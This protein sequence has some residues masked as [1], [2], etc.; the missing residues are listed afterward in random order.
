MTGDLVAA[1]TNHRHWLNEMARLIDEGKVKVHISKVFPLEQVAEAHKESE[2]FHTRGKLV[3]E[4]QKE[5]K[6]E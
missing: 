6:P 2:T 3:L 5:D 1:Q 4:I